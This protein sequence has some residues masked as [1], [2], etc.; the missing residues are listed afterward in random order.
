MIDRATEYPQVELLSSTDSVERGRR[1]RHRIR[2][3][4]PPDRL[5]LPIVFLCGCLIETLRNPTTILHPEFW[6]EDGGVWFQQAYSRGWLNP[7]FH[8][9]AGYLQT[10]SRLIADVGLLLPLKFVPGLF[11]AVA[12]VVQVLPAVVVTSRR[13]AHVAPD[14]RIRIL[15]AGIYL[16]LPDSSELNANLTNA[17]WHLALLA[18][19]VVLALPAGAAWRTFDI[20]VIASSGLTGPFILS[21]VVVAAIYYYFRRRKWTLVVGIIAA[22]TGVIQGIVLMATPRGITG[23]LDPSANLFVE[24]VGGRV[25]A[26]TIL[27][28]ATTTSGSFM[29]DPLLWSG[30][31]L[32]IGVLIVLFAVCRGPIE[33]KL[34]NL[35]G[36]FELV[37]ALVSPLVS[38]TSPQWQVLANGGGPRYW[39]FPALALLA[40]VVWIAGQWRKT[41]MIG[42]IVGL[43]ALVALFSFGVRE[44]FEYPKVVAPSWPAQVARFDRLP[45]HQSFTF[46]IRPPGWTMTLVKN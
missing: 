28:T 4:G 24:I 38:L 13:F 26:N 44:D 6:A 21:V 1:P 35:F 27:G 5:V 19:L 39:A 12:L 32:A 36:F 45:P 23:P 34:F 7:L 22:A 31:S 8:A 30:I 46:E 29:L 25:F 20:L 17:Q 15:L 14:Y 2:R 33:L 42:A 43:L 11:V 3:S 41:W 10:F 9:Q 16:L 37:A 40:D 18:V